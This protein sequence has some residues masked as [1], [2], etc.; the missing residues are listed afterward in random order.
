LKFRLTSNADKRDAI[1]LI[2]TPRVKFSEHMRR[3]ENMYLFTPS[4]QAELVERDQTR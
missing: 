2:A 3:A 1:H 4:I